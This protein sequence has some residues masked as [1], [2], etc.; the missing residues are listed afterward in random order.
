MTQNCWLTFFAQRIKLC[1]DTF[2]DDSQS[3][4]MQGLHISNDIQL[5]LD[6]IDYKDYITDN[7]CIIIIDIYTQTFDTVK[8]DFLFDLLDLLG[9]GQ[10]FKRAIQT[11]YSDYNIS[12]KLP[13][14]TTRRFS[15][16]RGI[17][18]EDVAS[19]LKFL[20]VMQ[21]MALHIHNDSFQGIKITD[22]EVK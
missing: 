17:K 9:F 2:I 14:G 3:G 4:F 21:T 5:I 11:L 18:Q 1:L 10:Y 15:I 22:R 19:L 13:R 7:C 12:V 16:S 20:L 6:L 8:H